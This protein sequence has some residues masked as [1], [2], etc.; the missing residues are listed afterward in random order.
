MKKK[1][2]MMAFAI[3]FTAGISMVGMTACDSTEY[4]TYADAGKYSAGGANIESTITD[5]EI[6]WVSGNVNVAY[7]DVENVTFSEQAQETL[8][9]E[10]TMHYW[11]ENAT[12]HIKYAKSGIKLTNMEQPAK[13]L[14][15]LLPAS[16]VLNELE[17]DSVDA[18][19]TV[20]DLN[21]QDV[22]ID[23]VA[24]NI[25]ATFASIHDFSVSLVSGN[26]TMRFA[27]VPKEG[28]YSNVH[29]DLTLYLPADTGFTAEMSKIN[30]S[31]ESEFDT[32]KQG[33]EYV[34]GNGANEYEFETVDGDIF[35]KKLS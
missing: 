7:G 20:T 33:D 16:L 24:G 30:G 11:L 22:E 28:D 5:I 3:I 34:C 19:V 23:N 17:I 6:D 4:F 18:N 9:Q 2:L 27:T 8:S 32:I 26:A 29:G 35:V 25:D 21:V 15:V 14:T 12:L 10:T 31:F 1:N 13:D